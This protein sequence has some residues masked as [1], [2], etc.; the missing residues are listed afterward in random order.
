MAYDLSEIAFKG[1]KKFLSNM[2]KAPI[3]LS[4]EDSFA[5]KTPYI[6]FDGTIY[7]T[8]EHFYQSMKSDS[9]EWKALVS[10]TP[11]GEKVKTLARKHLI[12]KKTYKM[13]EDWDIIKIPVMAVAVYLKFSQNKELHD[14]LSKIDGKIS[15]VNCWGDTF[16][17][18]CNGVGQ[19]NLGKIITRYRSTYCI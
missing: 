11:D 6:S 13:R 19:D 3:H 4:I 8:S 10:S 18:V 1:E 17:G 14:K 15:E 12:K 16:W 7:P 5:R 2:Y 9:K